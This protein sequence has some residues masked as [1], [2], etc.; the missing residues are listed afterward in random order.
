MRAIRY[1]L[2][3]IFFGN[4]VLALRDHTLRC[5]N[6]CRVLGPKAYEMYS[7]IL[8]DSLPFCPALLALL[9]RGVGKDVSLTTLT[10]PV[11]IFYM[12]LMRVN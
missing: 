3:L 10:L 12:V 6:E 2:T 5:H 9:E 4:P 7:F 8:L 1:W 11:F